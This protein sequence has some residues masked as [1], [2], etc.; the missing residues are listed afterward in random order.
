MKQQKTYLGNTLQSKPVKFLADKF[1]PGTQL[2]VEVAK[3]LC[4]PS[5][6][7]QSAA[8]KNEG[9]LKRQ[10]QHKRGMLS[11]S[12]TTKVNEEVTG[13]ACTMLALK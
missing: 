13:A 10:A 8:N 5:L 2:I 1:C 9:R 11:Q 12:K 6:L 4:L 3:Q 7:P